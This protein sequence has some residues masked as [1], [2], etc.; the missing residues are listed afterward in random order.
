MQHAMAAAGVAGRNPGDLERNNLRTEQSD[1]P[2]HRADGALRFAF[3]PVHVLGPVKGKGFL[4]HLGGKDLRGGSARTFYRCAN[5]FTLRCGQL[6]ESLDRDA[7][8]FG[9]RLGGWG[10]SSILK[11]DL[12]RRPGEL[13]LS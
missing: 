1:D 9:E 6:F 4:W 7:G 8:L 5:V 2:A 11:R 3:A 13:I 12:P 10:G